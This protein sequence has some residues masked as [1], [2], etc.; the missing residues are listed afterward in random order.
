MAALFLAAM[1]GCA[2]PSEPV[3]DP[4]QE[5]RLDASVAAYHFCVARTASWIDDGATP[6]TTE[7]RLALDRCLPLSRAVGNLLGSMGVPA[8][9]K[10]RFIAAMVGAAANRSAIM[11][12]RHRIPDWDTQAF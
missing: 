10:E 6:V 11:L 1:V 9:Q 5:R 12:R 8:D 7:S 4:E 2:T 3:L